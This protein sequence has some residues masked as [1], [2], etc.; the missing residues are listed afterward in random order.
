MLKLRRHATLETLLEGDSFNRR[1]T[2]GDIVMVSC[3]R[4]VV[5]SK[6]PTLLQFNVSS[7]QIPDL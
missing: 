6:Q 3:R 1:R 5:V 2:T 7:L 4:G